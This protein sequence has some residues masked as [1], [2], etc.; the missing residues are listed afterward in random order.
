MDPILV[1]L[2]ASTG[3]ALASA[4][5]VLPLLGRPEVPTAWIGW[6]NALAGGMMLGLAYLLTTATL[7]G[8]AGGVGAFLGILFI[9]VTRA[10][11]GAGPDRGGGTQIAAGNAHQIF[12]QGLLHSASEGVAIAAAWAA[13]SRFG[14]FMALAVAIHNV[15]EG[16]LLAAAHQRRGLGLVRATGIVIS[17]NV[18]QILL[19]V[20]TYAVVAAY[21]AAM[22][23]ATGFAAGT[24]VHLVMAELLPDSYRHAGATS[25]AMVTAIAMGIVV[26]GGALL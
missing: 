3:T 12:L 4:A 24:L 11:I 9:F 13:D 15:P 22:P 20:A 10:A 18:T 14:I 5:G 21:P 23:W 1:I 16:T 17:S 2:V 25:I 8:L 6:S 26:L 7:D 19:A